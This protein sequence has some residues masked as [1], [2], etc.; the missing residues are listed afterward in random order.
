[1]SL[2]EKLEKGKE[3]TRSPIDWNKNKEI[4]IRSVDELFGKI[5]GEWL[6]DLINDGLLSVKYHRI[7]ITEE[8]M[9]TY[10]IDKL[11]ICSNDSSVMLEPV[12]RNI[13]G[14]EGR[15]DFFLKGEYGNGRLLILFREEGLDRWYMIH[16][17]DKRN[18]T[19][20]NKE[21]LE[22]ALEEW[23]QP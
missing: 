9:G 12:G 15:I 23:L 19:L 20:L 7:T 21:S 6:L 5:A 8:H 11:E 22:G 3:K 16:K 4:W 17:Q 13:I 10:D 2:R 14:G 18:R 1:M